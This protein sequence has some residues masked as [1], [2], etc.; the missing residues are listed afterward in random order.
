[1]VTDDVTHDLPGHTEILACPKEHTILITTEPSNITRYGAEFADQFEYLITNQDDESLPH[2]NAW[3]TQP[4]S[5]WFYEK[6]YDQIILEAPW[7]KTKLLSAIATDKKHRHTL[8]RARYDFTLKLLDKLHEV[9]LLFSFESKRAA[10]RQLFGGKATFVERKVDMI[11]P[12]KYHLAIGNQAGPHILT[13]RITDAF[14]G[15]SVPITY[16]CTNLSD[17]FPEESYVEIDLFKPDDAIEKIR[18]VIYNPE[19]YLRRIEFVKEA[20]R[21][22]IEEYNLPVMLSRIIEGAPPVKRSAVG[23][24]L[25]GRRAMRWRHPQE[26]ARFALWR[27]RN[28]LL[29]GQ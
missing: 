20:R 15:Y 4:G 17:Y 18:N 7:Q 12:Y 10:F 6:T 23:E 2:R 24:K 8:H 27:I 11:D 9:D 28:A 22:V 1:V 21:R 29:P 26:F 3:R 19:D 14:L 25:R 13:E 5:R 16:G